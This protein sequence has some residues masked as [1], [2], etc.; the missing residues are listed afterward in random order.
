[1]IDM[2]RYSILI[3]ILLVAGVCVAHLISPTDLAGPGIDIPFYI[4]V[5]P[6]SLSMLANRFKQLE[7]VNKRSYNFLYIRLAETLAL[8]STILILMMVKRIHLGLYQWV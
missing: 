2:K 5:V 1:M 8:I 6:I 7:S 4:L 3:Y